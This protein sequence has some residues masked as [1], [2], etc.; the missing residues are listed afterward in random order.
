MSVSEAEKTQHT[1]NYTSTHTRDRE[2][3]RRRDELRG[4]ERQWLLPH[5]AHTVPALC[6]F[7][8]MPTS[9]QLLD[10]EM[11]RHPSTLTRSQKHVMTVF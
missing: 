2:R 10:T 11:Y 9:L 6:S 1:H 7:G 8:A 4:E 3:E 5:S